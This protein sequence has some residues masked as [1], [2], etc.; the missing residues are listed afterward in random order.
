M[1][2]VSLNENIFLL[3]VFTFL[4]KYFYINGK[5]TFSKQ[6]SYL[7][8]EFGKIWNFLFNNKNVSLYRKYSFFTF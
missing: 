6:F 8:N 1:N 7:N 5:Y 2:L 3:R 4:Y